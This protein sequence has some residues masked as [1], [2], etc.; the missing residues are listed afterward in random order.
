MTTAE[1][2]VKIAK[3]EQKVYEAGQKSMIDESKVIKKTVNGSVIVINDASE[4][5]HDVEVQLSGNNY[6]SVKVFGESLIKSPLQEGIRT[7]NGITFTDNG[8][9]TVTANGTATA[10][11]TYVFK[12]I[13][14]LGS[15]TLNGIVGGSTSTYFMGLGSSDYADTG[16]GV[17]RIYETE[18]A[19]NVF[20][21]IKSGVTVN[22]V[23]FVPILEKG[24]SS[25]TVY[26][27]SENGYVAIK[28]IAPYMNI[29]SDTKGINI[30]ATYLK[31]WGM[32]TEYNRFWDA[33]QN[34]GNVVIGHGMFSGDQWNDATY[35][36]KYPIKVSLGTQLFHNALI[37][38]TVVPVDIS[39][40]AGEKYFNYCINLVIIP[41][42]IVNENTTFSSAFSYC[43]K[44]EEISFE[45]V[46]G[47]SLDL[48]WSTKL[49]MLSLASI[50]GA[51]SKTVSGQSITLPT[52]ARQTYDNATVSGRWDELVAEYPNWSFKYS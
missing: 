6:N 12:S 41:K 20:L 29:I 21:R 2:L 42:L 44:L 13:K 23:V 24:E 16:N 1:K 14:M 40:A 36:P 46:I 5:P 30:T 17:K 27:A 19:Q 43:S 47:K 25:K 7:V 28:R 52:T 8:N 48:H 22:N 50:V 37:T 34:N 18:T 15:Y 49:S 32:Q 26:N 31:S 4:V 9:G 35:Q 51:L 38:N 33:Y 45:G 10:D 3:N 11:A 39:G